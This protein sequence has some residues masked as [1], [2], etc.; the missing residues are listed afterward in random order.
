MRLKKSVIGACAALGLF[1]LTC[2]ASAEVFSGNFLLSGDQQV[3]PNDSNAIGAGQIVFDSDNQTFDLSLAIFGIGLDDLM[4]VGPNST[5]VHIHMA[6]PGSN[7]PI[8]ID[9]GFF[10]SFQQQGL[11]LTLDIEDVPFGGQQG[12]VFSDIDDNIAA[13]QQGN[14]YVNIHTSDFPGGEI[15]GQLPAIPAPGALALLGVAG[16]MTGRRRRAT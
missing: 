1:G 13:L 15:R 12:N 9:V 6:P 4:N 7:G 10:A 11:G 3:P 8:V 16:V 14:L 5:P 2:A